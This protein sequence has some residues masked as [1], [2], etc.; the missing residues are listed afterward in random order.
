VQGPEEQIQALKRRSEVAVLD[1][2]SNVPLATKAPLAVSIMIGIV[3]VAALKIAPISI[4]AI[5]GVLLMVVTGCLKW[6]HATRVL[7]SSLI[8]LTVAALALSMAL[9]TTG[10]ATF[11]A[12]LLVMASFS[13][14]PTAVLSA[15][16]LL[17]AILSMLISNGAAAV[18]GTP[19]AIE[20]ARQLGLPPEP[21]VL[22]VLF[23][24]NLGYATPMAD[25]CN[26]LVFSAGGYTFRDFVRIGL[27]LTIIMWLA[28]SWT[29]PH[30]YPLS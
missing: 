3:A 29:L 27:P 5:C 28:L 17:M 1:A 22:A 10:G 26:L 13:L 20:V 14:P 25:N 18:I 19:I 15:T 24:V 16:I 7:D 30:F 9:V 2:T 12:K 11:I 4:A 8:L 6:R 21:F 23:G